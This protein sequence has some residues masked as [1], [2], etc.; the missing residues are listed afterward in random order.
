MNR[1][2]STLHCVSVTNPFHTASIFLHISGE[3]KIHSSWSPPSGFSGVGAES[4][5]Q[6]QLT[7]TGSSFVHPEG[8]AAVEEVD[9]E[10]EED[11]KEVEEVDKEIDF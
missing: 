11:D 3:Y 4:P 2:A 8:G 7:I 10:D 6:Y 1:S 5:A 9:D